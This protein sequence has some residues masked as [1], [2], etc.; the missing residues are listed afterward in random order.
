M[1]LHSL[2]FPQFQKNRL[3]IITEIFVFINDAKLNGNQ[4]LKSKTRKT[5]V[6]AV[7]VL[8]TLQ[9]TFQKAQ[10]HSAMINQEAFV[11]I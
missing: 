9:L 7:R 8:Q 1:L 11:K 6:E 3:S 10:L 2:L 5:K 4:K